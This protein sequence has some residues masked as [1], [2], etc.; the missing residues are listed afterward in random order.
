MLEYSE[1]KS[2]ID[3]LEISSNHDT[4]YQELIN[5]EDKVLDTVNN[6]IKYYRD[7]EIGKTQFWNLPVSLVAY[8]FFS[9][10][11]DIFDDIVVGNNFNIL[12]VLNKDDRLVYIGVMLIFVSVFMY[13]IEI[14]C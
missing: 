14:S 9:V 4:T 2:L 5:K 8:R 7:D 3:I 12:H 10:W 1:Y 6:V 11:K 13:Y